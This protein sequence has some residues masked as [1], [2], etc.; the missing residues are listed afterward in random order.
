M[1]EPSPTFRATTWIIILTS[2][3]TSRPN[4][5]CSA[6]LVVDGGAAVISAD[7]DCSAEVIEA[8]AQRKLLAMTVGHNGDGAGEGIRVAA[9]AVDGFAQRLE[10]EHR[11]RRYQVHLPL[12]G[13]I[14][15]RERGGGRGSCDRNRR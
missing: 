13:R 1:R 10:L 11:G 2:R 15:D 9:T 5:G 7:H 4:F 3:I 6:D 8:A 12:V 14:P